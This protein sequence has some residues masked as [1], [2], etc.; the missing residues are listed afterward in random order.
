MAAPPRCHYEELGLARDCDEAAIKAAYRRLA[1][2]HHPDKN[3]GDEEAAAARFRAVQAA[4][5][6]LSD[7]AERAWYDSHREVILRADSDGGVKSD[8]VNIFCYFSGGACSGPE[9]GPTGFYTVFGRVF[10]D[11]EA[12][13]RRFAAEPIDPR[14][15]FPPLSAGGAPPDALQAFYAFWKGY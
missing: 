1:L 7:P 12:E 5:T 10:R 8:L 11:I 3:P 13:E 6:V 4:Y 14:L 9:E 15:V 2:Q